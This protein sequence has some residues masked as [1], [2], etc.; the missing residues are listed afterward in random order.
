[1]DFLTF[2]ATVLPAYAWPLAFLVVIVLFKRRIEN[3]LSVLELV[4]W[5]DLEI[6]FGKQGLPSPIVKNTAISPPA[7][8]MIVTGGRPALSP[9]PV[10][11][12]VFDGLPMGLNDGYVALRYRQNTSPYYYSQGSQYWGSP[13]NLRPT[14]KPPGTFIT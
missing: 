10:C 2:L 8:A 9:P 4:K 14:D 7:G 11:I 3:L 6:V 1:M 12:N 13:A 5:K